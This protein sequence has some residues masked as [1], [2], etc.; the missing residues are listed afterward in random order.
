[1]KQEG[2]M[3]IRKVKRKRYKEPWKTGGERIKG[4]QVEKEIM[5]LLLTKFAAHICRDLNLGEARIMSEKNE[6]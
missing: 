6:M 3:D 5:V 2:G 1:M 4:F